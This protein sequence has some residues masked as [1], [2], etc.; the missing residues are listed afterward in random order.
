MRF[1]SQ[2]QGFSPLHLTAGAGGQQGFPKSFPN[3]ADR[4]WPTAH[5]RDVRRQFPRQHDCKVRFGRGLRTRWGHVRQPQLALR[6]HVRPLGQPL[7]REHR[8]G[9]D[10]KVRP[11]WNFRIDVRQRRVF[12]RPRRLG[13]RLGRQ[14]LRGQLLWRFDFDVRFPGYVSLQ[15]EHGGAPLG[16]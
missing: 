1:P 2:K 9:L 12:E 14:S 8:R 11:F 16:S 3:S 7:C 15:L 10:F 13:V 6:P 5:C 4:S